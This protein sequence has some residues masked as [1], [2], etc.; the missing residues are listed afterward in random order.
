MKMTNI[1]Q[2][3]VILENCEVITFTNK[4]IGLLEFAENFISFESGLMPISTKIKLKKG[5]KRNEPTSCEIMGCNGGPTDDEGNQIIRNN[6]ERLLETND[7]THLR[8]TFANSDEPAYLIIP[9]DGDDPNDD[10]I[11]E[12]GKER[13]H[14]DSNGDLNI[15]ITINS[16]YLGQVVSID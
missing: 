13:C 9:Y 7:I 15:S 4:D 12:R 10:L 8:I 2:L 16:K 6:F 5:S 11:I 1:K 3:D 14:L